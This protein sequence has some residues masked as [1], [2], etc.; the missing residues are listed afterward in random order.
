MTDAT[1]V[2]RMVEQT[3]AE[4]GRVDILVNDAAFNKE[5]AFADLDKLTLELWNHILATNLTGTFNC[6]K[7]VAPLMKTQGQGRIINLSSGA[8]LVPRGS[9]IAY[10]VSSPDA[11]HRMGTCGRAGTGEKSATMRTTTVTRTRFTPSPSAR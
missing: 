10:A 1:A 3:M 7:A 2:A 4:F 9:S 5:I 11:S 8:G 6:I